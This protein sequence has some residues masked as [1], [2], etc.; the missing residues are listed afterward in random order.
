M[1]KHCTSRVLTPIA[2]EVD[3]V[4]PCRKKYNEAMLTSLHECP[5]TAHNSPE[6]VA[7]AQTVLHMSI[8]IVLMSLAFL[9]NGCGLRDIRQYDDRFP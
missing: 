2:E 7:L 5:H 1:L 4:R 6:L 3:N 9:R 8:E